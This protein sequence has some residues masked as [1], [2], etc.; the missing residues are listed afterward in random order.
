MSKLVQY[1]IEMRHDDNLL[2]FLYIWYCIIYHDLEIIALASIALF[3][4]KIDRKSRNKIKL[5]SIKQHMWTQFLR[6]ISIYIPEIMKSA[7]NIAQLEAREKLTSFWIIDIASNMLSP[8]HI[9]TQT[10]E[11]EVNQ[12]LMNLNFSLKAWLWLKLKRFLISLRKSSLNMRQ[13][14]RHGLRK[15]L[16]VSNFGSKI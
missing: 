10:L 9:C 16:I 1:N 7:R 12:E 3:N 4:R 14:R 2:L 15:C 11:E 5:A 8:M 13:N 6:R